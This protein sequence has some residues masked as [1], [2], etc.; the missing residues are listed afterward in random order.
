MPNKCF[1]QMIYIT[2]IIYKLIV[3]I[4][5][6][7]YLDYYNNNVVLYIQKKI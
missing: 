2:N 6:I 7:I 1:I 5:T 4:I 3:C